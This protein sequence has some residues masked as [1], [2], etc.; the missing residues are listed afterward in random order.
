M[1]EGKLQ[2]EKI[3]VYFQICSYSFPDL[4]RYKYLAERTYHSI[5]WVFC[6][7]CE[8]ENIRNYYKIL[9][10]KRHSRKVTNLLLV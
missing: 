6:L 3:P 4:V 5:R 1:L 8:V 10:D 2:L 7:D 9:F